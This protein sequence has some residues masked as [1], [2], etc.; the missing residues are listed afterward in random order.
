MERCECPS[1]RWISG[2]GMPSCNSS[3]ACAWRSWWGAKRRRTPASSASWCSCEP[4]GAGRPRVPARGSGDHAEQRADRQRRALGQPRS[5]RRPPPRVHPDLAAAVVLAVP[6]QNR[7][8]PFFQIG[9]GQRERLVDPQ[10]GALVTRPVNSLAVAGDGVEDLVGGL[11]PD[12]GAGVRRSRS[13]IQ[14]RMSALRARTRGARR[15]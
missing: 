15:A 7:P 5:E 12:V 13:S 2:S 9:L 8:A 4:G 3:T 14:S 1:W 10:P 11:G 6:D